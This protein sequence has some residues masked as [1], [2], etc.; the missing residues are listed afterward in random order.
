MTFQKEN[1]I[2]RSV[3]FEDKKSFELLFRRHFIPLV[4]F[5]QQFVFDLDEAKDLV[6]V[7]FIKI[8]E[9]RESL[10]S[11]LNI[12]SYLYKSVQN[13]CLDHIKH[14]KVKKGHWLLAY[15]QLER[16]PNHYAEFQPLVN[17]ELKN[18]IR[19]AITALPEECRR[20]FQL[21]RFNGMK[22]SEIAQFLNI[23]IKT[24]E[25]QMS[26]ALQKLRMSLR[27]FLSVLI[28]LLF[29]VQI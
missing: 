1:Q 8:W 28:P 12:Q 26:T 29:F 18:K 13:Q 11:N 9:I 21:S 27:E 24:V 5:A 20:V 16:I 10:P 4:H 17:D 19:E 2:I 14:L 6:Q 3:K 7:A 23:S 15:E 25:T 22:Y